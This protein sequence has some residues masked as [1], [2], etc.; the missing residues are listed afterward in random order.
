MCTGIAIAGRDFPVALIEQHALRD[1]IVV[2]QEGADRELRFLFR[3]LRPLLPAWHG[4]QLGVY[5][6]GNRG[7]RSRLPKTA[8][9]RLEEL[10]AGVWSELRPDQVDIPAT[11]GLERGV[12]FQIREGVR[13]ILVFDEQRQPRVYMLT[14]P[15]SHYYKV[16]TRSD[17]MP[18][19]IGSRI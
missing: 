10:E 8:W 17:R 16:M 1:R 15:A 11:F 5:V 6:W 14:E 19:F 12:W 2:R 7:R 13:G 3:D 18:V 9:A 4:E